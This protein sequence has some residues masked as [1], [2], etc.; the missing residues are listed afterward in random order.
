MAKDQSR[1][2]LESF[3]KNAKNRISS[4]RKLCVVMG[5][6]AADLDSMVSAVS[7]AWYKT[8]TAKLADTACVPL[9]PISRQ[10][11]KL[12]T[13][14]VYLFHEAGI[15]E[16]LFIFTDDLNL[17]A[18]HEKSALSLILVDHNKL[19]K[20]FA[21][22]GAD[23]VE[24]LDHHQ[25]ENLYPEVK[26]R[27]I[28]PVGSASTL[29]AEHILRDLKTKVDASIALLLAGTILL[30]TVNLDP[31]A[32]RLTK[33]DAVA[34]AELLPIARKSQSELFDKLQYEK[35]N[36]ANLSTSDILRK[37]YKG[38]VAGEIRYGMSSVLL[39]LDAWKKKDSNLVAE[40]ASYARS[41]N[42]T[43]LIVMNA[44]T[45][46]KF[47][48]EL[49]LYSPDS[50]LLKKVIAALAGTDLGLTPLAPPKGDDA[51]HYVWYAQANEAYSRKKLQPLVQNFLLGAAL[52][53]KVDK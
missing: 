36:V 18:L 11:F 1:N 45:K 49:A 52:D 46:P 14:A 34:V 40:F 13:E 39:S 23:V 26:Y 24:I 2:E 27:V 12:R 47:T 51:D 50:A 53:R 32:G 20:G 5:N 3:L 31:N 21:E 17:H 42:L 8:E 28:E 29:V 15:E 35:F 43:L 38:Y 37:D 9:I 44:Y 33:K 16:A 30:D 7:Y 48:R 10:D 25:D 41:M 4:T 22:Y 19:G 6:E